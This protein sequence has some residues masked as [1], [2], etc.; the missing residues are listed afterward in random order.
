M[1]LEVFHDNE[2][3]LRLYERLGFEREGV[4]RQAALRDGQLRDVVMMAKLL[5]EK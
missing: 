5:H 4:M 2:R 3:A 1:E